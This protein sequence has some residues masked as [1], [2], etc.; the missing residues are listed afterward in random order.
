MASSTRVRG[1]AALL[2][3]ALAATACVP[4]SPSQ[5][6]AAAG[7]VNAKSVPEI[8]WNNPVPDGGRPLPSTAVDPPSFPAG[9]RLPHPIS[10][11]PQIVDPAIDRVAVLIGDS[12][13]HGAAGVPA[14]QTWVELGLRA[15]GFKVD[16]IAAGGV[17]FVARTVA[18]AN[19]PDAVESGLTPLPHGNPALIVIQGGGND[20]SQGVPDDQILANA[21]RLLRDLQTDY[22]RGKFLMIGTIAPNSVPGVRRAEV[23]DLLAGFARRNGVAFISPKDWVAR[24][25]LANKMADRVHLTASG[26]QEMARALAESL[27]TLNLQAP[28]AK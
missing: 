4:T 2:L 10:G 18:S 13:A 8:P 23:D 5:D 16:S 17:G 1:W 28:A 19:F 9:P 21:A 20:A 6:T 11:R 15:R 3:C 26:H 22:P 7:A 14:T 24:Y 25:G 27:K 12:Q